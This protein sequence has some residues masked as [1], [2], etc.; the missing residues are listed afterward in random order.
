MKKITLLLLGLLVV[1]SSCEKDDDKTD[2]KPVI[3]YQTELQT[4][5]DENWAEFAQGKENFPG[6]YALQ[7][8]SP[9]GDFL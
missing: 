4:I 1:I 2:P 3:D 9:I 6:G 8:L 5:L 7:L